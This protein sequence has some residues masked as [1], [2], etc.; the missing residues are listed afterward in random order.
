MISIK[1]TYGK[2]SRVLKR[3][4]FTS[5]ITNFENLPLNSVKVF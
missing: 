4:Q 1:I 2:T 5:L 3:D